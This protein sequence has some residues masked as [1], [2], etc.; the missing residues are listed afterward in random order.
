M[1]YRNPVYVSTDG[2]MIDCELN[3]PQLGWIPFTASPDDVEKRGRDL[4]ALIIAQG[5]VIEIGPYVAPDGP[6]LTT[7]SAAPAQIG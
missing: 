7:P 5:A 1:E 6:D 2:R 4:H 3:H